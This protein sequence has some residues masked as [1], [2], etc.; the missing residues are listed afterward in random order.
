VPGRPDILRAEHGLLGPEKA[1][2]L[3]QALSSIPKDIERD[4]RE[5]VGMRLRVR[6]FLFDPE[7]IAHWTLVQIVGESV[8]DS[9]DLVTGAWIDER[10]DIAIRI[11]QREDLEAEEAGTPIDEDDPDG[12]YLFV[13][14]SLG[15]PLANARASVCAFNALELAIRKVFVEIAVV[16]K[17][18]AECVEDG[19][20]SKPEILDSLRQALRSLGMMKASEPPV[21]KG[22]E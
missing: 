6:A 9:P 4:V 5:R 19:L 14:D 20:G 21:A 10:I 8:L 16:G 2:A 13:L 3:A 11:A 12:A 1:E 7:R 15:V 17:P 22:E 18:V